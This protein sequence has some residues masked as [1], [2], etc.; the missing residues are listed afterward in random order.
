LRNKILVF[1]LFLS[2][3]VSAGVITSIG[4]NHD[5]EKSA[6]AGQYVDRTPLA[7]RVGYREFENA[8]FV[9]YNQFRSSEAFSQ[10]LI[11]RTHHELLIWGRHQFWPN[12]LFQAYTQAAPGLQLEHVQ[13]NFF[14]DSHEDTSKPVLA[15]AAAAGL[16]LELNH[17]RLELEL[18]ALTSALSNPNPTLGVGFYG[19]YSF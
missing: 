13:T 2:V 17:Y 6:S 1:I 12:D 9:E 7:L 3:Q 5:F 4:Q 15:L 19:G 11:S 18:R 16:A 10:L 8:M 14:S